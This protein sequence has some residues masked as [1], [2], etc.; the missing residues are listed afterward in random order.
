MNNEQPTNEE[1]RLCENQ[2]REINPEANDEQIAYMVQKIYEEN[3]QIK[4]NKLLVNLTPH[5]IN[6]DK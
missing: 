2:A 4:Y 6:G 1:I 5:E 3:K